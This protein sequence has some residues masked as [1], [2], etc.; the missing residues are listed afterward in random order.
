MISKEGGILK[1][2]KEFLQLSASDLSNYLSCHHLT[3]L[4][5]KVVKGEIEKPQWN[6]P[7][8]A[9]MQERGFQH[10]AAYVNYLEKLGLKIISISDDLDSSA[11]FSQT[12][13]AMKSGAD[14]IVQGVLKMGEWF[15]K[16]DILKKVH[17]NSKFGEF[18]Y[19]VMDTKL[20]RETK[21]GAILQLCLYSEMVETI[22]GNAPENMH[23][24]TPGEKFNEISYRVSEYQSYY[25]LVRNKLLETLKVSAGTYPEPVPHCDICRWEQVCSKK[26]REDDHLSL[27]AG[28]ASR[29]RR[30]LEC[31]GVVTMA[32]LAAVPDDFYSNLENTNKEIFEQIQKQAEIQV[33][34]RVESKNF[35]E[36]LAIEEGRGLTRLP[37]ATDQDVFFDIEGDVFVGTSGLEYLLGISFLNSGKLKYEFKWALNPSDEKVAFEWFI[38]SFFEKLAKNPNAHIYHYA[39]YEPTACKRLA[40][41]YSTRELELDQLL[42]AGKFIDLY[43]VV[44]QG[45]RASVEKYSIKDLEKFT[46]YTRKIALS[47]MGVHK[48]SLEHALELERIGDINQEMMNAVLTYNK[49]DTDST[50]YL[51]EWLEKLRAELVAAGEII[52]RPLVVNA[53]GSEEITER[54]QR[55]ERIKSALVNGISVDPKEQSSVEKAKIVLSEL[56]SFNRREEKVG[57]WEVFR[58]KVMN[59]AELFLDKSGISGLTYS[60]EIQEGR[61]LPTHIYEY[62]YQEV[63]FRIGDEIVEC[64]GEKIGTLASFDPLNRSI[65]IKKTKK[66]VT[67][68]PE[69]VWRKSIVSAFALEDSNLRFGE[70]VVN[71]SLEGDGDF[72]AVRD[73]LLGNQPKLKSGNLLINSSTQLLDEVK[74]IALNLDSSYLPIQGPPGAG[75][76]YTGSHLIA[77]LI[78]NGAKIGVTANSHKVI[79]GL[80]AKT[81]EVLAKRKIATRILQKVSEKSASPAYPE[82]ESNEAIEACVNSAGSCLVAGTSWLF[83]R[84]GMVGKLDYLVI[85]E[86]GQLSLSHV[87]STGVSAKN[88]IL[89]GD[90]QQL[91]QPIQ[92]SHPEGADKSALEYILGDHYAIPEDRGVF[93]PT[94]FRCHSKIADFCSELFYEGRLKAEKA[95][96]SNIIESNSYFNSQALVLGGISHS[97]NS[98]YSLEEVAHVKKIIE[99]L[100]DGKHKYSF[101]NHG[102]SKIESGVVTL[103]D[104]MVIAPYN[105]QVQ[106]LKSSIQGANC[107]TVDKFQG[108]E[109][110]IVIYSLTTSSAE[111]APR[112]MDFLYSAHRLNVAVSRAQ[113]L[114]VMVASPKNFEADCKSPKQI[115]LANSFCRFLEV[116]N[117]VIGE[118]K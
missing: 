9:V 91:E 44:R 22:V 97:G 80:M 99:L 74:R 58:L 56:M 14:V 107:G 68:H 23:V 1:L 95:N 115:K 51:R 73:I 38:D 43:G 17:G 104:I 57:Y 39:P 105:A 26:R 64:N 40:Q 103:N 31:N 63:D 96:S 36:L 81:V 111:D 93:L 20:S 25:R 98:N 29:Q 60:K 30:D 100:C 37:E 54:D 102:A 75:K 62:P 71:N 2:K 52:L 65:G 113:C 32:A 10:E 41:K 15:G 33:R 83:A 19:E 118:K 45:V 108:R 92:A 88:I 59:S 82:T 110:P 5:K 109:A 117:L 106:R 8:V 21:A 12:L 90:P 77:E 6:D 7:H 67:V 78:A 86:A 16:L 89:L 53:E 116:T 87:V 46:G 76:S 18:S 13:D 101:F 85:D 49:D 112:G 55:I 35:Y 114:F 4:D 48:R 28:I 24:V 27:V 70:W 42:R 69:A 61:N 11:C 79:S 94:T 72:K 47:E 66:T 50:Y 84:E 34:A 3:E